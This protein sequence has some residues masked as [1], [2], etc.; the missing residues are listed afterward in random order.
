MR[1]TPKRLNINPRPNQ[2][3]FRNYE[4]YETPGPSRQQPQFIPGRNQRGRRT[5]AYNGVYENLISPG[6]FA[7]RKIKFQLARQRVQ[8]ARNVIAS[9][10]ARNV[11]TLGQLRRVITIICFCLLSVSV[12]RVIRAVTVTITRSLFSLTF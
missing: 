4:A 12:P 2:Q 11:G 8:R 3:Y 6:R 10:I 1:N 7:T 5:W 9:R